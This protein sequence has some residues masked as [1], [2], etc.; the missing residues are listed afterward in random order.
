MYKKGSEEMEMLICDSNIDECKVIEEFIKDYYRNSNLCVNLYYSSNWKELSN[1]IRERIVDVIIIAQNGVLGLDIIT[2][3][4]MSSGKL[5][6][7]SDLDFAIQ[8]YRLGVL[9]FNRK[10]ITREKMIRALEYVAR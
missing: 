4:N 7:F 1:D 5:I 6:W 2:G 9:Y 3:L 10:P 8:A